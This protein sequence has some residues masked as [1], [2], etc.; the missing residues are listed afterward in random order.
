MMSFAENGPGVYTSFGPTPP[1]KTNTFDLRNNMINY[2]FVSYR[3]TT[4]EFCELITT[5]C[6]S[7]YNGT[8]SLC[9]WLLH[10]TTL[11]LTGSQ[12]TSLRMIRETLARKAVCST[13][14]VSRTCMKPHTFICKVL[15]NYPLKN[16]ITSPQSIMAAVTLR[17][18]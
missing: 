4:Y 17:Q 11:R 10:L 16:R 6:T 9:S 7:M 15:K 18:T 14:C 1:L 2:E 8:I 3:Q 5:C 13:L 12:S